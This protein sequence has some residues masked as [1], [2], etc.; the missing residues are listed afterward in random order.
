MV[1]GMAKVLID[2]NFWMILGCDGQVLVLFFYLRNFIFKRLLRIFLSHSQCLFPSLVWKT[3]SSNLAIF[4]AG[5]CLPQWLHD[6]SLV[7][8]SSWLKSSKYVGWSLSEF[9]RSN[10]IVKLLLALLMDLCLLGIRVCGLKR[11]HFLKLKLS[12]GK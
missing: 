7:D 9:S 8:Y 5:D 12:N 3:H 4:L 6:I 2:L 1:I 11:H 10:G